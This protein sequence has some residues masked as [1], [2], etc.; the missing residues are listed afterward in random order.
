[1]CNTNKY[2]EFVLVATVRPWP[3]A[4]QQSWHQQPWP[5][6]LDTSSAPT[7]H[8]TPPVGEVMQK[9][10]WGSAKS[11]KRRPLSLQNIMRLGGL[12]RRTHA[13]A[14]ASR[15]SASPIEYFSASSWR[16]QK[17]ELAASISPCH[18]TI[19]SLYP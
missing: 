11:I 13:N 1:M 4:S 9:K 8:L 6:I 5:R 16:K 10:I 12:A 15:P 3:L 7:L 17:V 2:Q 18:C 19:V 14:G